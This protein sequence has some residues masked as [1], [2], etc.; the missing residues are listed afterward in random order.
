MRTPPQ[1]LIDDDNPANLDIFE[2]RTAQGGAAGA[3][4]QHPLTPAVGYKETLGGPRCEVWYPLVSGHWRTE[5]RE[6]QRFMS[7]Y[8][9]EADIG[10]ELAQCLQMTQSGP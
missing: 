9:S 1:I 3:K 2:M 5:F 7:A 4:I 8:R 10:D 6:L